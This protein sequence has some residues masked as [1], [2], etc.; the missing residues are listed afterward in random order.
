M[1][2]WITSDTLIDSFNE[3][4]ADIRQCMLGLL[5]RF[6]TNFEL[7][8]CFQYIFICVDFHN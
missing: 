5:L 8:G 4:Y 6:K 1:L 3:I 2:P 7:N